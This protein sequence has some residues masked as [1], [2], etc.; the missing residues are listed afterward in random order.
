MKPH[1]NGLNI[2]LGSEVS[3]TN[4]ILFTSIP[5]IPTWC[6]KTQSYDWLNTLAD[7]TLIG[8]PIPPSRP[9]VSEDRKDPVSDQARKSAKETI[10][11][12]WWC[13]GDW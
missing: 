4:S 11:M 12:A 6:N 3:I 1:G 5:T 7:W 10:C 9:W 2:S 8:Q 13:A